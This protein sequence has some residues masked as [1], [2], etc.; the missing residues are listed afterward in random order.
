MGFFGK[1][2]SV[3]E[4]L[5]ADPEGRKR[6]EDAFEKNN[7]VLFTDRKGKKRRF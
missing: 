2:R 7:P 4:R 1:K 6:F 3:S 5:K